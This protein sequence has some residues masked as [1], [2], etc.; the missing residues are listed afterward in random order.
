MAT[1]PTPLSG[2]QGSAFHRTI[3]VPFS[4]AGY[5]LRMQIRKTALD[6]TK[7]LELT[8]DDGL[9]I[10]DPDGTFDL[11]ITATQMAALPP[12]WND[13]DG[14]AYDLELVPG[15]DEDVAFALLWGPFFVA[16]EVTR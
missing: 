6:T 2:R 15:G 9:T 12:T 1:N 14:W 4:I 7:L 5:E 13:N 3:T 16:P 11:D 8:T 10:I